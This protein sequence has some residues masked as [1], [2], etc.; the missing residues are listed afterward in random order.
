MS[1]LHEKLGK[2]LQLERERQG[3][4]IS[5]LSEE[6]KVS[7]SNLEAIETGIAADLPSDLYYNLFSKSYAERLGI[8]YTKTMDAIRED[9]GELEE[10]EEPESKASKEPKKRKSKKPAEPGE[11]DEE[12]E[13]KQEETEDDN[14]FGRKLII[15]GGSV[16]VV[17][18]LFFLG[19]KF[20]FGGSDTHEAADAGQSGGV[21]SPTRTAAEIADEQAANYTW[22]GAPEV[23]PDSLRLKVVARDQS[24]ATILA[25][26]DTAIYQNLTPLRQ[27]TISAKHRLLISIGVPR[28]VDITLDGQPVYLANTT[29]GRISRVEINQITKDDFGTPPAR[30][31]TRTTPAQPTA[32]STTPPDTANQATENNGL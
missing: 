28:V 32:P 6:L 31:R 13:F 14:G 29:S 10:G 4:S 11:D 19:F 3:I 24:W 30:P 23:D 1:E 17:F 16:I 8:D 18:V 12:S 26:G 27:Y 22:T 7:E 21:V 20:W 2:L 25:D 15:I 9:L 5:D